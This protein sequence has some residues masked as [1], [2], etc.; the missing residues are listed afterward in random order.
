MLAGV[1]SNLD[2]LR[3][4]LNQ[5]RI[6][7]MPRYIDGALKA[8]ERAAALTHR[9]LAFSR[10]QRLDSKPTDINKLVLS[11]EDLIRRTIGPGIYLETRLDGSLWTAQCDPNQLESAVLN[12]SINSRDA[13]PGGGR[14]II[15]TA[16][17]MLD[18]AYAADHGDVAPGCYV[19]ISVS[20]TG[21]GMTPEVAGR[22]L[23][24]FFTTKPLGQGTG[25]GLSMIYGFVKQSQGHMRIDSEPGRGTSVQIFLPRHA[26]QAEGEAPKPVAEAPPAHRKLTVLLVDDEESV[27]TLSTELLSELGYKVLQAADGPSGVERRASVEHIDLLITDVGLPNG[28]NG[29]QLADALRIQQPGL[30][31]LFI[32]GFAEPTAIGDQALEPGMQ[33]MA[34]PFS[35]AALARQV[36]GMLE[37]G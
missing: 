9:L 30:K 23:E 26:G 12:L 36:R 19:R 24:P 16:N 18:H 2:M 20:D 8:V 32:T 7:E 14:L 37:E 22:V 6:D 4:R 10:R 3:I 13:M 29:R 28:M 21:V 17:A 15:E 11:L 25:L 33:L 1:M 34:K 31:V 27:R 5:H 35:M